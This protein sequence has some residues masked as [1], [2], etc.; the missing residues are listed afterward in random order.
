[1]A[2]IQTNVRSPEQI[3]ATTSRFVAPPLPTPPT[4]PPSIPPTIDQSAALR[5][6][7]RRR[8]EAEERRRRDLEAAKRRAET[9]KRK[10]GQPKPRISVTESRARQRLQE[11]K[12]DD[13]SIR[14]ARRS[15]DPEPSV[16]R[17]IKGNQV[18]TVR[19][20]R[21]GVRESTLKKLGIAS[22]D[23]RDSIR[24]V[25]ALDELDP[26]RDNKGE[27]DIIAAT[28]SRV[29]DQT[30]KDAGIPFRSIVDAKVFNAVDKELR[31]AQAIDRTGQVDVV[32]AREAGLST[33]LL[34][35]AGIKK[36]IINQADNIIKEEKQRVE[37][38]R[39]DQKRRIAEVRK[40]TKKEPFQIPPELIRAQQPPEEQQ[41]VPTSRPLKPNKVSAE[42]VKAERDTNNLL[43][44]AIATS[45]G[46]F[47]SAQHNAIGRRLRHLQEINKNVEQ[48]RLSNEKGLELVAAIPQQPTEEDIAQAKELAAFNLQFIPFASPIATWWTWDRDPNWQ[49]GLNLATDAIGIVAVAGA[50]SGL[51]KTGARLPSIAADVAL[52]ELVGPSQFV[53]QPIRAIKG[54]VKPLTNFLSPK[55]LS[56]NLIGLTLT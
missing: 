34:L 27:I 56:P 45:G 10:R 25:N 21:A 30:F 40:S 33:T 41:K 16:D 44:T 31:E 52:A 7:N 9:L 54:S 14:I 39:V 18:E 28:R 3:G 35:S 53:L 26:F 4:P 49:R 6:R 1:M 19:A 43:I 24:V 22:S 20:L 5:E 51:A 32:K 55:T 8:R 36:G 50:A 37:R 23:I 47:G 48:G 42:L 38:L 15:T 2:V 46:A 17:F 13:V 11:K 29:S 12:D